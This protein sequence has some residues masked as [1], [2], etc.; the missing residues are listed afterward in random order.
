M[1][2]K[3]QGLKSSLGTGSVRNAASITLLGIQTAISAVRLKCKFLDL[4]FNAMCTLSALC[5]DFTSHPGYSVCPLLFYL[6][7]LLHIFV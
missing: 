2:L 6:S 5:S 3:N 7:R 1:V 4:L